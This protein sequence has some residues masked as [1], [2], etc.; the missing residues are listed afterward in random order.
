[1]EQTLTALH[2]HVGKWR[3]I[4][5]HVSGRRDRQAEGELS[6][7]VAPEPGGPEEAIWVA[8]RN[9]AIRLNA[10]YFIARSM[11]V[12][13]ASA[14]GA[15]VLTGR[16]GSLAVDPPGFPELLARPTA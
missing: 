15:V 8:V 10:A 4:S 9:D 1:M 5:E 11:F 12:G 16:A 7:W 6:A 14:L 2:A 3:C 13:G